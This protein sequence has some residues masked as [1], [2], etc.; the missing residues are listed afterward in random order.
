VVVYLVFQIILR[1]NFKVEVGT[2]GTASFYWCYTNYAALSYGIM[3]KENSIPY[4]LH[5]YW[6]EI[7]RAI[8][9]DILCLE[10]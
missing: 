2:P 8:M 3:I 1:P 7:C 9:Y 5:F 4:S 6:Q 10:L